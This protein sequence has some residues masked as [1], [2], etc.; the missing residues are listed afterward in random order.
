M[1]PIWYVY[2]LRVD[3]LRWNRFFLILIVLTQWQRSIKCAVLAGHDSDGCKYGCFYLFYLW[4]P[5]CGLHIFTNAY[6]TIL[7]WTSTNCN[8]SGQQL[9]TVVTDD[10]HYTRLCMHCKGLKTRGNFKSRRFLCHIKNERNIR[11]NFPLNLVWK[12][13]SGLVDCRQANWWY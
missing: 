9:M 8:S 6:I 12:M 5:V 7:R 3:F 1:Q 10:F 4:V 11:V 13:F 2:I